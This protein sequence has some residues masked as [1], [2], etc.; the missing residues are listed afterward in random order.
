MADNR[1]LH[2]RRRRR[3]YPRRHQH[4]R[5]D[6]RDRSRGRHRSRQRRLELHHP[7]RGRRQGRARGGYST[8]RTYCDLLAHFA[9]LQNSSSHT[10]PQARLSLWA[11]SQGPRQA[12][13]RHPKGIQSSVDDA[14]RR[15]LPD[16]AASAK[17][18]KLSTHAHP[19]RPPTRNDPPEISH[20]FPLRS[21]VRSSS[22]RPR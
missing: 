5:R 3:R 12:G 4:G 21:L 22:V 19:P 16:D 10:D 11:H 9:F 6:R 14:S 7:K 18:Q 20:K 2:R 1:R 15:R 13:P 17:A 8:V